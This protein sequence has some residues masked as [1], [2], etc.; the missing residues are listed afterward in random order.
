MDPT[1]NLAEQRQIISD[2]EGIKYNCSPPS[3]VLM[4]L[5]ELQKALDEWITGGGALPDSW[6]S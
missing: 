1:A 3:E 4:H 6:V 2:I 5:L